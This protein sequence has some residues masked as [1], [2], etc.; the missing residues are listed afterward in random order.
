MDRLEEIFALQK[1]FNDDIIRTRKLDQ[2]NDD[3]WMQRYMM[4]MFVEM[5]E[6]MDETNYKWWKNPKE[7]DKDAVKEEL[8][9]ILHFFVSLCIRSGMDAQDLYARYLE[10]NKENILRQQGKGKKSGYALH[11]MEQDL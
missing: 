7:V 1:Q 4:A 5:A 6:L 11:E 2:V 8:V 9:D 3:Q 10:K